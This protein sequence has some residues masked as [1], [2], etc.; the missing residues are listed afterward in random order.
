MPSTNQPFASPVNDLVGTSAIVEGA[1]SYLMRWFI[2][3]H[4]KCSSKVLLSHDVCVVHVVALVP[5]D[6]CG[7]SLA[8]L[9][10]MPARSPSD[11]SSLA[12]QLVCSSPSTRQP[13]RQPTAHPPTHTSSSFH[14][15]TP[16]LNRTGG[17]IYGANLDWIGGAEG[18]E[19][20]TGEQ[21]TAHDSGDE[22]CVEDGD[23]EQREAIVRRA[24]TV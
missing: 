10:P 8:R 12:L 14:H 17:P 18:A 22:V 2:E 20:L 1:Q 19:L 5:G 13:P 4:R 15:P 11:H 24:G 16:S 7:G 23:E 3:V 21:R 9:V 6:D